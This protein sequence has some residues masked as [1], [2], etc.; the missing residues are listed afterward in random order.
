MAKYLEMTVPRSIGNTIF[1]A[2]IDVIVIFF[3]MLSVFNLFSRTALIASSVWLVFVVAMVWAACRV[4]GG[5]DKFLINRLGDLVGRQFM[6]VVPQSAQSAEIR[7][8]YQLMGQRFYQCTIAIDRIK[9][10]EWSPGQA[11]A[12]A[13]RDMKDWSVFLWFNREGSRKNEKWS[14]KPGQDIHAIGPARRREETEAFGLLFVDF[15]RSSGVELVQGEKNTCF[16]R[17]H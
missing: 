8:G 16:V 9:S 17:G 5:P 10:V 14:R 3:G 7:F 2:T 11:S 4:E 12:V 1:F 6:L 15:L 13:G